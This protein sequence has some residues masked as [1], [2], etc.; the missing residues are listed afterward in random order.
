MVCVVSVLLVAST[1]GHLAQL[2][3]LWPR[4]RVADEQAVWVTHDTP[5]SRSLLA[6]EEVVHLDYV[7][8]RDLRAV[9][10]NAPRVRRL[11]R[12]RHWSTAVSTGAGVALSVLPLARL[13][14][15][16]CHYIESAAR[17]EGPSLT[18]RLLSAVPGI[19]VYSQYER[20]ASE[21]WP[22]LGSVFDGYAY[23]ERPADEVRRALV[24]LG[25]I[26]FP[27]DSL[28]RRVRAILPPEVETTWQ[29]GPSVSAGPPGAHVSLPAAELAR[30]AEEADVV[31]AHAGVGSALTAL[32]A[33]RCPIL[34]PRRSARG[35]HV[36]DHQELIGSVLQQ[37][38]IALT[39]EA[40]ALTW[41]DVVAAARGSV[42][43]SPTAASLRLFSD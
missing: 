26:P 37:R 27:F 43:S 11:L 19:R 9:L 25:T 15:V 42:I 3:R 13:H 6:G 18:G 39:R 1:G 41:D 12:E 5:Q 8:P 35:E 32:E 31:I 17:S 2:W 34:V 16:R 21:R 33:G 23:R 28:V 20:W 24:T 29:L 14:G 4:L 10:G 22:Y 36:D 38:G 40:D 30:R 7:A